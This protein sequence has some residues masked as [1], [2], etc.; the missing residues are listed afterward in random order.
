[1]WE[2]G[3]VMICKHPAKLTPPYFLECIGGH[4]TDR[5]QTNKMAQLKLDH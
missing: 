3:S 2:N 1:M 5:Y 4:W